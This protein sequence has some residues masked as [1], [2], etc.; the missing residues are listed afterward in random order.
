MVEPSDDHDELIEEAAPTPAS[1]SGAAPDAMLNDPAEEGQRKCKRRM[2]AASFRP[3]SCRGWYERMVN[4]SDDEPD[5]QEELLPVEAIQ[6]SGGTAERQ[7]DDAADEAEWLSGLPCLDDWSHVARC[8]YAGC[9]GSCWYCDV[10]NEA[11]RGTKEAVLG[12]EVDELPD[13]VDDDAA[14]KCDNIPV[15]AVR[16]EVARIEQILQSSRVGGGPTLNMAP[17]SRPSIGRRGSR[18]LP[19]YPS[20]L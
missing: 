13:A 15:V 19:R 10:S 16:E 2:V 6:L 3:S 9:T 8:Q 17:P 20:R 14:P 1:S 4:P 5:D 7:E 11:S 18:L 12:T